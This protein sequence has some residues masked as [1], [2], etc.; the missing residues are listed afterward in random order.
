M[1]TLAQSKKALE[2]FETELTS[3]PNVVGLGIVPVDDP[4]DN[5][6]AGQKQ[7]AVAVYVAKKVPTRSLKQNQVI[8]ET[9]QV[10]SKTGVVNVPTKVIEQGPVELEGIGKE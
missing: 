7:M 4:G 9:L 2:L 10:P 3:R 6:V 5:R 8:P 1:A